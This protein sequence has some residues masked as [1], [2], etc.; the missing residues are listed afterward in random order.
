MTTLLRATVSR[1]AVAV[2][3][4]LS[5]IATIAPVAAQ[6]SRA[7]PMATSTMTAEEAVAAATT[8]DGVLRFDV[9]ENATQFVFDPDLVYDD[10]MPA[11]GATFI[12]HAYIYP[13]GTLDESNG[14]KADGSPEFPDKVLGEWICRG[15]FIG[16]GMRT[17]SGAMVITTQLY[18]FGDGLGQAMLVSDG[19]ELA[20]VGV[21]I[22]RAITG[23]TG[24]FAGAGG[25]AHQTLLGLNATE[26]VNL[27]FELE[28]E[29]A[30][31]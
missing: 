28:L 5:A 1:I 29:T 26:G 9:S 20:D 2:V 19:Y 23:G 25:V 13:A 6:E 15:W 21:E 30:G 14:V 8:S 17:T 10:G 7:T 4:S 11:Y 18:T 12:T 31:A 24:P 22:E 27:H 16:E 3:F